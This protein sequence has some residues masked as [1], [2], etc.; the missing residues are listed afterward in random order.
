M[1]YFFKSIKEGIFL[2][3]EYNLLHQMSM[4]LHITINNKSTVFFFLFLTIPIHLF[5]LESVWPL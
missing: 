2:C 5:D 3:N 1:R 4:M